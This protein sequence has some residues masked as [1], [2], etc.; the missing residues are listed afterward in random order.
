[1]SN[2]GELD[3]W[4]QRITYHLNDVNIAY[5]EGLT[6]VVAGQTGVSLWN[7]EWVKPELLQGFPLM[8]ICDVQKRNEQ[9]PIIPAAEVSFFEY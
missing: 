8:S 1:M 2:T 9:T 5:D 4:L 3:I 7:N 6:K